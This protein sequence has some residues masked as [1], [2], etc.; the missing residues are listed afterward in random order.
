[1]RIN[2]EV[3]KLEAKDTPLL[4]L[5]IFENQAEVSLNHRGLNDGMGD[6]INEILKA[7]FQGKV[8]NTYLVRT[9]G[10]LSP[11]RI[12][13]VGLGPQETFSNVS[14]TKLSILY[15]IIY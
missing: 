8:E 12:L 5:G 3:S 13:L 10:R 14:I 1:M 4:A 7:D 15:S 6:T 2:V 9:N 11:I